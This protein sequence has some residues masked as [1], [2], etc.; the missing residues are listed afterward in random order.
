[1]TVVSVMRFD[2]T[3]GGMVA[4]TQVTVMMRKQNVTEKIMSIENDDLVALVSGAGQQP[5]VFETFDMLK[6]NY[7]KSL[8]LLELI[9]KEDVPEETIRRLSTVHGIADI[10]STITIKQK[11]GRINCLFKSF[12][13]MD[14]NEFPT[15]EGIN[16]NIW[17]DMNE[18]YVGKDVEDLVNEAQFVI[19][20]KDEG[21]VR[22][23]GLDSAD[24]PLRCQDTHM[25]I[26]SGSDIA[27]H[28]L[29]RFVE[30]LPRKEWSS[31]D[32]VKGMAALL[33]ATNEA[34]DSNIGV[35]GTPSVAYF[36][37]D[38][39]VTMLGEREAHLASEI[40][41]VGDA[42]LISQ[43]TVYTSLDALLRDKAS[44]DDI[45]PM[46][47]KKNYQNIN[48]FLRRYK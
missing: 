7:V 27:G 32:L 39:G 14:A 9:E 48:R 25:S 6:E 36:A 2:S 23:Y 22:I 33:R 13:N 10:I 26:G 21:G 46:A 42:H 35:G 43:K 20:G 28:V 47:F 17:K 15:A 41:R 45:E 30:Y 12:Y 4:D 24:F 37:D 44:F 8:Q 18:L 5:T 16:S 38:L 31:I 34:S 40:V 3:S 1:M 19:I 11:R 29:G